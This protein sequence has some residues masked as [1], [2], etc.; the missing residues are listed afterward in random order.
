[1]TLQP[2]DLQY[3]PVTNIQHFDREKLMHKR[4]FNASRIYLNNSNTK[5]LDIGVKPTSNH[6]G[7]ITSFTTE[8]FLDGDKCSRL[9]L[10]GLTGFKQLVRQIRGTDAF[11]HL[12]SDTYV[13]FSKSKQKENKIK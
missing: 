6:V 3:I 9:A 12:Q 1:M 13:S 8:V 10:G 2:E 7:D 5:W 11:E 4:L